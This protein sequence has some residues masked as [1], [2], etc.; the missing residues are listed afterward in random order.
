MGTQLTV[1]QTPGRA[2][3]QAG[4]LMSMAPCPVEGCPVGAHT[5]GFGPLHQFARSECRRNSPPARLYFSN[6]PGTSP[7]IKVLATT[8]P[9]PPISACFTFKP[10]PG[11]YSYNRRQS[12]YTGMTADPAHFRPL[13]QKGGRARPP[14]CGMVCRLSAP[15]T[16]WQSD[17]Q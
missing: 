3:G 1:R 17:R 6:R 9:I 7:F 2:G 10:A 16:R 15:H 4:R 5:P 8:A 13:P 14:I 11:L 12:L